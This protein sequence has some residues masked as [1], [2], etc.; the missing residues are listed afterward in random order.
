MPL[1]ASH[2]CKSLCTS[3]EEK[4]LLNIGI[5][6]IELNSTCVRYPQTGVT[7]TNFVSCLMCALRSFL[8]PTHQW[9]FPPCMR[10][11]T[12]EV[13]VYVKNVANILSIEIQYCGRCTWQTPCQNSIIDSISLLTNAGSSKQLCMTALKFV[14]LSFSKSYW[15]RPHWSKSQIPRGVGIRIW[16]G[17]PSPPKLRPLPFLMMC[18]TIISCAYLQRMHPCSPF[19]WKN[20]RNMHWFGVGGASGSS[21]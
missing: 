8:H 12:N 14:R 20:K 16:V 15:R 17:I 2:L 21:S 1:S 18:M 4:K 3:C 11:T 5:Q 10:K 7:Q 9:H 6:S 19:V 13:K